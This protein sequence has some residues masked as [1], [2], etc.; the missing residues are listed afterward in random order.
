M[1]SWPSWLRRATVNRKIVSSTLTEVVFFWIK[2]NLF[3]TV[4]GL[5]KRKNKNNDNNCSY[6]KSVIYILFYTLTLISCQSHRDK[7]F[8][9][10]C[11]FFFF[12]FRMSFCLQ[13]FWCKDSNLV[14]SFYSDADNA[15]YCFARLMD[16]VPF[17]QNLLINRKEKK[18]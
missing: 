14:I 9:H 6:L 18:R 13:L 12:F 8:W 5:L 15:V 11:L 17:S 4:I 2:Q 10:S 16:S 7:C 1:T 3:L